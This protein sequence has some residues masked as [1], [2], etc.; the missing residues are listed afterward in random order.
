MGIP[1][2]CENCQARLEVPDRAAG[3]TERCPK[4]SSS[5]RIPHAVPEAPDGLEVMGDVDRVAGLK[6]L[7]EAPHGSPPATADSEG[8]ARFNMMPTD[9]AVVACLVLQGT[10]LAAL[11]VIAA[12]RRAALEP[13]V[14][15]ELVVGVV[16]G[17]VGLA[18][19]ARLFRS[20]PEREEILAR[21]PPRVVFVV[22]A[23]Y[24]AFYRPRRAAHARAALLGG[25]VLFFGSWPALMMLH[26]PEWLKM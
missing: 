22:A 19:I 8:P 16:V 13:L 20:D 11:A 24:Y 18:W 1:V 23:V 21:L 6:V 26:P 17:L 14:L 2:V 3:T 25:M 5:V 15:V 12:P 7:G 10:F 4:C 9:W